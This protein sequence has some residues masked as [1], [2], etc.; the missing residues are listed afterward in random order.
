MRGLSRAT[1]A[2]AIAAAAVGV[3][4]VGWRSGW[5][6]DRDFRLPPTIAA[7]RTL[8]LLSARLDPATVRAEAPAHPVEI[9]TLKTGSE[10]EPGGGPRRALVAAPPSRI[11]LAAPAA[12]NAQLR[13]AIGIGEA[14]QKTPPPGPVQFL[15]TVNGHSVYRRRLDP[16]TEPK[17]VGWHEVTIPLPAAGAV[18]IGLETS[19]DGN[20][21]G[22]PGWAHVRI[23]QTSEHP[24]Q[25]AADGPNVLFLLVDTMRADRVGMGRGTTP[26]LDQLAAGGLWFEHAIAA[27][28][29][30]MLSVPSLFT[31]LPPRSHGV[32]GEGP[33]GAVAP[34]T[35]YLSDVLPTL[36]D[37]AA[38][39]G[40]STVA[41]SASPIVSRGTNL[42][43]GF[44]TVVEFAAKRRYHP[45]QSAP[46]LARAAQL[47]DTFARWVTANPHRRFFAYLHYMEAHSPYL[48]AA[49]Q[50]PTPPTGVRPAAAGGRVDELLRGIE[51]GEPPP[52]PDE[53][54]HLRALYDGAVRA[55]DAELPTLLATLD[56]L[57]VRDSTV[58][59]ITADH[60][61]EF[62][63]HG[64]L[65][66]GST[67]YEETTRVPLVIVG[68]GIPGGRV[69]TAAR[70]ADVHAT[71][72]A[73]LGLPTADG[74]DVIHRRTETAAVSET[75]N[76]GPHQLVS[77]RTERWK[78]IRHVADG[79]VELYD[80]AADPGEQRDRSGDTAEVE[81]LTTALAE[82]ERQ[83]SS[84]PAASGHDPRLIEKLRGLGY[85]E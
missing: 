61:E 40:I 38:G 42:L 20:A 35:T 7:E 27:S 55:W 64:H 44:E 45:E 32:W 47:H 30:T 69:T 76:G 8:A 52:T 25:T 18:E 75:G 72:A 49:G 33:L 13:F 9:A 54:T 59:V 70:S 3:A 63:E 46:A 39:A 48:P 84:P 23:V 22:V 60:G 53:L 78:L 24:R 36:A 56:G 73:V 15:A 82:W 31:G 21:P 67:L 17:D 80:L 79:R 62:W 77:Y 12:P 83:A 85:V 51:H 81:A 43:K 16:A 68:P 6:F 37:N 65:K 50:R 58:I 74:H 4:L 14:S 71:V 57:G 28:S 29:W 41:L 2:V 19:A 5:F 26:H 34:D 11:V 66:H 10:W 1:L